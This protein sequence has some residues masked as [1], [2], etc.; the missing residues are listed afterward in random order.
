MLPIGEQPLMFTE[1]TIL[2]DSSRRDVLA[3]VGALLSGSMVAG[4]MD[5]GDNGDDY[6]PPPGDDNNYDDD[7]GVNGNGDDTNGNGNGNGNGDK[8]NGDENGNGEPK[9]PEYELK[10]EIPDQLDFQEQEYAEIELY[11]ERTLNGETEPIDPENLEIT[12]ETIRQNPEYTQELLKENGLYQEIKDLAPA[13]KQKWKIPK[14]SLLTGNNILNL[15]I[16]LND[17]EYDKQETYQLE[18]NTLHV[19]KNREDTKNDIWIKD[20]EL[21]EELR[22]EYV[23]N[24]LERKNWMEDVTKPVEEAIELDQ[25]TEELLGDINFHWWDKATDKIGVAPSGQAN[26]LMKTIEHISN[27]NEEVETLH[28]YVFRNTEHHTVGAYNNEKAWDVESNGTVV[29][30]PPVE[31][32]V[33][34][35]DPEQTSLMNTENR[36]DRARGTVA[37][38]V[39]LQNPIT[40]RN[41]NNE[42]D[43]LQFEE[44]L[45]LDLMKHIRESDTGRLPDKTLHTIRSYSLSKAFSPTTGLELTAEDVPGV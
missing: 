4:C 2:E 28:A 25:E 17:T 36:I 12:G 30:S 44:E 15:K 24:D 26:Y 14:H 39:E 1:T 11:I 27:T 13:N 33:H 45:I 29:V 20:L 43:Y 9:D 16:Q 18:E 41:L 37:R 22:A 19:T 5:S 10:I 7:N 21:W 6:T 35:R 8:N 38:M 3:G 34:Q 42:E 32:N 23:K 40:R 31:G